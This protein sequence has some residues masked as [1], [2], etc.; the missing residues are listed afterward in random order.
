MLSK[1]P[2]CRHVGACAAGGAV[3]DVYNGWQAVVDAMGMPAYRR[4]H[5]GY[6]VRIG[7]PLSWTGGAAHGNFLVS[8]PFFWGWMGP[9][10]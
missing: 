4:Y 6:L 10:V 2:P 7:F 8:K 3:G 1:Q 5:C 9:K